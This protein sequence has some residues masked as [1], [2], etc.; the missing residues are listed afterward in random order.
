MW[1]NR[2]IY[3][4]MVLQPYSLILYSFEKLFSKPRTIPSNIL[5]TKIF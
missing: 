1:L 3:C 2:E 5:Y 4:N